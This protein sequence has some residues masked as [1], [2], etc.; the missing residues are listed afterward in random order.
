MEAE[1]CTDSF[2]EME[3]VVGELDARRRRSGQ[4]GRRFEM[5]ILLRNRSSVWARVVN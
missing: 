1:G 3:A 4:V 2:V 5:C